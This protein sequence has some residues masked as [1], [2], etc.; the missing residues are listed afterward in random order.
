MPKK[1]RKKHAR[2]MTTE[3]AMR[4]LFHPNVVK[5]VKHVARHGHRKPASGKGQ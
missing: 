2:E 3:E 5:H 1:K 4:H